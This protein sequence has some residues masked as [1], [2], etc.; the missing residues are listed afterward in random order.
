MPPP[1]TVPQPSFAS[2][3]HR[4]PLSP[5]LTASLCLPA[6]YCPAPRC[7]MDASPL[8]PFGFRLCLAAAAA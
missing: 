2:L 1:P 3:P 4:L 7:G 8:P 6:R 5:G